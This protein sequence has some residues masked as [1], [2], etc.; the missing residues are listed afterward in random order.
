MSEFVHLVDSSSS[1]DVVL[2]A[3]IVFSFLLVVPLSPKPYITGVRGKA[4]VGPTCTA[5][6]DFPSPSLVSLYA[7][8]LASSRLSAAESV[9][10]GL[11][12]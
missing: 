5:N 6:V 10:D 2:M 11:S 9:Q 12:L 3:L 8:I 1:A 7:T 4:T